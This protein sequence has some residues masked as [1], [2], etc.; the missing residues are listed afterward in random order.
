MSYRDRDV[1]N[2]I[3]DALEATGVFDGVYLSGLPENRGERSGNAQAV[4]IE[5]SETFQG[6]EWDD[7][8]G[9]LVMT[10]RVILTFL[11]RHEDPQ[12]RDEIVESLLNV[13]ANALNG[14]R[15]ADLTLIPL[16]RFR[17]WNWQKPVAPERRIVAVLEY[18]YLVD[19]W[20]GFDT[21][22]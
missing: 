19:G 9:A 22:E 3:R 5:P 7:T 18:Q 20:A 13:A 4:S 10:S 17:S 1:R 16:T 14:K 21:T 12:I 2:S 11:A 6:D 15:L 8:S